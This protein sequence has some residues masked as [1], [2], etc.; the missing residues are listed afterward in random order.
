MICYW[1][2]V[3][4]RVSDQERDQYQR[5]VWR[6]DTLSRSASRPEA[7]E[8]TFEKLQAVTGQIEV[9][10]RSALA[11]RGISLSGLILLRILMARGDPTTATEL[12][13]SMMVTNGAITGIMDR[14]E[15]AGLITRNRVPPDRRVVLVET[16]EK[17]RAQFRKL[18][19]AA[20]DELTH[21]FQGWN[22]D[23]IKRLQD[24]LNRLMTRNR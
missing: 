8:E 9:S 13:E 24:L 16:T 3:E 17:A 4:V 21:S 11:E 1:I 23:D 18:R 6:F 22:F 2:P 19:F 15:S 5:K 12:A 14:L 7:I 10:L 20:V